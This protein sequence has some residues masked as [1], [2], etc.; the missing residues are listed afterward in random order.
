MKLFNLHL[1]SVGM[2]EMTNMLWELVGDYWENML[3]KSIC[4]Y[5]IVIN[6]FSDYYKKWGILFKYLS[7]INILSKVH[8]IILYV[9]MWSPYGFTKDINTNYLMIK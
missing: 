8:L 4:V 5:L 6:N 2:C 3:F 7:Y 1:E 9:F